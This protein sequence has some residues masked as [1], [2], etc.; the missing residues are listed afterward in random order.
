M[1]YFLCAVFLLINTISSAYA[2][3]YMGKYDIL[4]VVSEEL[5]TQSEG[6]LEYSYFDT[7][8]F[9][10]CYLYSF[11]HSQDN[12]EE[13]YYFFGS[14]EDCIKINDQ[15]FYFPCT[16]IFHDQISFFKIMDS[17]KNILLVRG[18]TSTEN[19]IYM[20]IFDIT[21]MSDIKFYSLRDELYNEKI[22]DK[23]WGKLNDKL[24]FFS[25]TRINNENGEYYIAPYFINDDKLQELSAD[26]NINLRVYFTYIEKPEYK[27]YIHSEENNLLQ[28]RKEKYGK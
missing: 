16:N 10:E 25:V 21:D 1:K 20:F 24:C 2:E 5:R 13:F 11:D 26:S 23:L 7:K 22:D 14:K 17:G 8:K 19:V 18:N 4:P 27:F 3:K 12:V 9:D 15:Y 28:N 6:W